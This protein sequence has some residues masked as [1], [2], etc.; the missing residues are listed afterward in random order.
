MQIQCEF[1]VDPMWIQ[2]RSNVN[3]LYSKTHSTLYRYIQSFT[4]TLNTSQA[5]LRPH[6]HIHHFK[7]TLKNSKTHS[8]LHRKNNVTMICNTSNSVYFECEVNVDSIHV[9]HIQ[10]FTD[11]CSKIHLNANNNI[12]ML[13]DTFKCSQPHSNVHSNIQILTDTLKCLQTHSNVRS[14]FKCSRTH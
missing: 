14:T 12:Q 10:H 9:S 1:N 8:K 11:K 2:C 7:Y 13:T 3:S 6:S 4:D 5:H